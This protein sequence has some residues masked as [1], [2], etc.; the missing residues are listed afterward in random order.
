M[1]QRD[2]GVGRCLVG[3]PMFPLIGRF[4]QI[5][6]RFRFVRISLSLLTGFRVRERRLGMSR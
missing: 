1:A 5:L 4:Y 3:I 6:D 2:F